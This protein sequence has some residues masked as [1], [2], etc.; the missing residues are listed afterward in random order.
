MVYSVTSSIFYI[1]VCPQHQRAHDDPVAL[2]Y[3]FHDVI[4]ASHDAPVKLRVLQ[5]RC[6]VPGWYA[7]HLERWLNFYHSSQVPCVFMHKA[8]SGVNEAS[9]VF[10]GSSLD[11]PE[12]LFLFCLFNEITNKPTNYCVVNLMRLFHMLFK[13]RNFCTYTWCCLCLTQLLVLDGQML[14]TE[15]A[16]VMDKIQK[17]LGLA[18]I[19]NYHKILA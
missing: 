7:I 18:N 12:C 4:T 11:T 10:M 6:L 19:I 1:C 17:F 14:K 5:N 9:L 13:H 16:S 8:K 3:S 15:P 2:K